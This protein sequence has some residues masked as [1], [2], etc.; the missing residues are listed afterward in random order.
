MEEKQIFQEKEE[1]KVKVEEDQ[2]DEITPGKGYEKKIVVF[3]SKE[4]VEKE[5]MRRV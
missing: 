5:N 4:G 1:E 2:K 3:E